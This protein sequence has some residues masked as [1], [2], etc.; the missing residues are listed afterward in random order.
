MNRFNDKC[1]ICGGKNSKQ[2]GGNE[3]CFH[4]DNCS[5]VECSHEDDYE[6]LAKII[7]ERLDKFYLEKKEM[8][9]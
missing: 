7:K 4:C 9:K 8:V 2:Y 5:F 3:R 6:I 1:P